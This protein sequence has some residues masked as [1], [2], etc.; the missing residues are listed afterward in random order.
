VLL[1][2][3]R[4]VAVPEEGD[5]DHEFLADEWANAREACLRELT[6]TADQ[7]KPLPKMPAAVASSMLG[8]RSRSKVVGTLLRVFR[9]HTLIVWAMVLALTTI[10][11]LLIGLG[12]FVARARPRR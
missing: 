4:E 9:G 2:V 8:T 6:D 10:A 5:R 3:V 11:V 12:L 7:D 1:D